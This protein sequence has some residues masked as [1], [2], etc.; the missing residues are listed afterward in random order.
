MVICLR[1]GT[2]S[3]K[4]RL[5]K[6]GA[7]WIECLLW[8]CCIVPGALYSLWRLSTRTRVCPACES[9]NMI[10]LDTP[11][12]QKLRRHLAATASRANEDDSGPGA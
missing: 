7:F 9:R 12:G 5:Y 10:P 3:E 8:L 4:G 1:C 6:E 11:M 2:V